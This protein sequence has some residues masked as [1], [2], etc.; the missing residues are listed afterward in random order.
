MKSSRPFSALTYRNF[1]L[2]WFGQ[3]ISL[4][5]TWMH[6]AAK[7]WLV[8][9]LTNS[10]F[11]LGFVG[12]A[13]S[14]PILLFTLAGG[15]VADRFPKKTILLT[16]QS[17]L[18]FLAF[19]L[20]ILVSTEVVT[21]WHVLMITFLLGTTNAFDIPTRQS[22]LVEMV[23]KENLLNAIALNSAAFHG[24]RTI[25]PAIAG[26]LIRYLGLAVC[27]YINSL[28]FLAALIGLLLMRFV[29]EGK[30]EPRKT[31]MKAEFQ[32][33]ITYIFSERTIYNLII[34]VGI[35]SFFGFPYI[36]FLPVYARDIL[37]TGAAGL[38]L[39]M[40]CAGVG[41]FIG[42]LSLA[43]RGDFAKK[44]VLLAVSGIIFSSALLIFSLSTTV[45]LSYVMLFL[46]GW[47]AI[48][49][50]ATANSL[51]QLKAPDRLR[52]RVMSSFTMV[53]L[54]MTTIG[55]FVVGGLAVYVGIQTALGV[56]AIFCLLG[57]L[58]LLWRKPE[59]LRL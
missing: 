54:G 44:G 22:F 10:P 41:A 3:I 28:S 29:R 59:I 12:S 34:S 24:A 17:I 25:G 15:V 33:G 55:N 8:F 19:T 56:S 4:T 37:K 43:V 23:G 30:R 7:G 27:F 57:I 36:N 39:L 13:A 48:S 11:Y 38:G 50:I 14:L 21:V 1:R 2:F 40:G 31:G 5:G 49:Q 9:K 51:I 32:E 46:V 52:G 42:A 16:T 18:M 26:I 53:F 6:S 47:G 20:A 35:I 45:W 58:W